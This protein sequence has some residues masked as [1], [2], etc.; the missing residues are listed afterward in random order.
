AGDHL[1]TFKIRNF[2]LAPIICYDIR[3]PELARVLVQEHG[4]DVILHCG[5]Y[6]RDPSFP[7]WH[8]FAMTRAIENQVFFL[9]LNRAGQ[10][11]GNSL[12]CYPWMDETLGPVHFA[13]HDED[14]RHIEID[15]D[16]LSDARRTF[17]FLQD[18]LD[19]YHLNAQRHS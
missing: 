11:Y 19:S 7:T 6:F 10:Q 4:V 17:T 14:F 8:A 15:R 12:F 3:F 9:S 13:A 5:A 18:K 2:T 1:F 16:R